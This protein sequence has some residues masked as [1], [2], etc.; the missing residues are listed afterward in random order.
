MPAGLGAVHGEVGVAHQVGGGDGGLG[1][2]HPDGG[3][4]P[5]FV[6]VDA[7][8][9]GEGEAQP[10]GDLPDLVLAGGRVAGAVADDEGGELVA[11]EPGGGVPGPYRVLEAAG[12]LD[13][14]LVAGL[15]AQA[16]VDPLEAV[17][18]DEEHGGARV[19][20]AAAGEG[21]AD[22]L[23]EQG[24]VGQVGE[25]VVLGV[26][27]Q[28]RLEP[29]PFGD[30]AA[31]ED[32]A[33]LVAVDRGLHIEPVAGARLEAALDPGGGLLG[34]RGGQKPAHLADHPAEILGVDERG[35]LGADELLGLAAVDTG[36]GGADIAQYPGRARRS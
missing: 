13:Q 36:G 26:V 34:R 23:G 27:L 10:V 28:L 7:V 11:A 20:R 33:A 18:V 16:V 14:Q 8:R 35:Q 4:H 30:V 1:E 12:R 17:E 2:G 19:A 6:A 15:V 21:L 5:H 9:L 31:V 29:D 24:A 32:Q 22:A 25:R 3:G